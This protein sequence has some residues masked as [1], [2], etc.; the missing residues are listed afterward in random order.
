MDSFAY[1]LNHAAKQQHAYRRQFLGNAR[2]PHLHQQVPVV[3]SAI[4]P[5]QI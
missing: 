1:P 3:Q 4:V 2:Q 5:S